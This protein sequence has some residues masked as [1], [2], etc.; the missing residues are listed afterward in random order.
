MYGMVTKAIGEMVT[1]K[2]GEATWESIKAKAQV[3]IDVFISNAAYPDELTYDLVRAAAEVLNLPA[4]AIL[5]EFGRHWILETARLGYAD[6]MRANGRTLP[7]FLVNL[8]NFHTRVAMI[9]PNL[10]PPRFEY[11]DLTETSLRLHY[12][13][14]RPGLAPFVLGLLQGLGTMYETPV[15]VRQLEFKSQGAPHDV[16]SVAW[17]A[18]AA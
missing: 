2:F 7:E 11:S 10:D 4:D 9:F 17:P 5:V 18:T 14:H 1:E 3:D 12:H 13:T 6:L 15:E 16:F 8:P